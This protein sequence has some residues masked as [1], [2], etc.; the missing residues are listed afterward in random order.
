MDH[1]FGRRTHSLITHVR[2]P[3][4]RLGPSRGVRFTTSVKVNPDPPRRES[5]RPSRQ[6]GPV[7][8]NATAASTGTPLESTR[9]SRQPGP[10][11]VN[12]TVA[13]T[14][15]PLESTRPSSQPEPRSSQPDRR[16]NPDPVRV[17]AAVASIRMRPAST[18]SIRVNPGP[19]GL[20]PVTRLS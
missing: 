8:V 5:T 20:T 3:E 16:V 19:F 17:N 7:R 4:R 14:R 13:S 12:A 6:P 1:D 11:R 2:A 9:P 15:T 10:P 18:G